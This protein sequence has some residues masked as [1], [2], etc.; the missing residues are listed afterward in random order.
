MIKRMKRQPLKRVLFFGA[1]PLLAFSVGLTGVAMASNPAPAAAGSDQI[2]L[3]GPCVQALAVQAAGTAALANY[4]AGDPPAGVI[5]QDVTSQTD[6][7]W[8]PAGAA[9]NQ[10]TSIGCPATGSL[11]YVAPTTTVAPVT[12]T[13]V[14]VT[15]TVPHTTTTVPVICPHGDILIAGHCYPVLSGI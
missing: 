6:S 14:E 3:A 2:V 4:Q 12:S 1:L 13:T 7:V 10:A 8:I 9:I 15:T 5:I 11:P